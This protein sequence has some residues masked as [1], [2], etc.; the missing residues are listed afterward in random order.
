MGI[1]NWAYG[2]GLIRH[3]S[4]ALEGSSEHFWPRL[5]WHCAYSMKVNGGRSIALY[6]ARDNCYYSNAPNFEHLIGFAGG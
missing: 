1:D 3:E 4:A 6:G 2:K 5:E